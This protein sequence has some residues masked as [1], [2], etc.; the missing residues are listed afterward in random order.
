MRRGDK[1]AVNSYIII[2]LSFCEAVKNNVLSVRLKKVKH[3]I[4]SERKTYI[5]FVW[6]GTII[7]NGTC[8]DQE[9]SLLLFSFQLYNILA[10]I[11]FGECN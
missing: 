10:L 2:F 6:I 8:F 5:I 9:Y 4:F 3:G 1:N 11:W 7:A